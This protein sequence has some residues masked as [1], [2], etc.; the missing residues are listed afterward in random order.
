MMTNITHLADELGYKCAVIAGEDTVLGVGRMSGYDVYT[1][2]RFTGNIDTDVD[3]K[4][5]MALTALETHDLVY[6]HLKAT[7]VI[8]HD[9]NPHGKVQAIELFDRMVGK[10]MADLP[11]ETLIAL[12]A[13]HSTPC[14]KGEHSGEP[15][16]IVISGPGIFADSVQTYDEATCS[17][18]GVRAFTWA[19]ICLEFTGLL[20]SHSQARKLIFTS[21]KNSTGVMLVEFF[22]CDENMNFS[23]WI[24]KF[25]AKNVMN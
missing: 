1:D 24:C 15:V 4:A 12:C 21:R 6:V 19:R 23:G 25:R 14:E 11:E 5:Q 22:L 8:G 2:K 3:L 9:N 18:G 7:D 16:P 20:R 13:D 17:Q 10:L